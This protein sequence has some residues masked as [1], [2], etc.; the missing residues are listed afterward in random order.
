MKRVILFGAMIWTSAC[1]PT[2]SPDQ[3]AKSENVTEIENSG[4]AGFFYSVNAP[5]LATGQKPQ[6]TV[7]CEK[8]SVTGFQLHTVVTPSR[9]TP[10]AGTM[11]AFSFD[12]GPAIQVELSW[13]TGDGWIA[14]DNEKNDGATIG[15]RFLESE[16]ATFSPPKGYGLKEIEWSIPKPSAEVLSACGASSG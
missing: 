15:T 5:A 12:G 9:P 11:G 1:S 10:L 2:A 14:R 6:F 3:P 7:V 16:R 13:L 8:G 4:S